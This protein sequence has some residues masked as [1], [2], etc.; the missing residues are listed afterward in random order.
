MTRA[1]TKWPDQGGGPSLAAAPRTPRKLGK[2]RRG[3]PR[4]AG[5][6]Q[7][8]RGENLTPATGGFA[9]HGYPNTDVQFV[10]DP[11]GISK[12][13]VYRYF[14]SKE[15]LFLAAVER[16]VRRLEEHMERAIEAI[17][18]PLDRIGVA[19]RAHLEF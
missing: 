3:R 18:D 19:V 16:G 4:D 9:R 10:A 1:S 5:L 14:P 12:G 13:T 7:R 11:L 2:R 15:R 6:R 17:R 8:R